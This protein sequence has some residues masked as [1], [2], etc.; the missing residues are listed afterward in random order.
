MSKIRIYFFRTYVA[1]LH[2]NEHPNRMQAVTKDGHEQYRVR[3]PK[4]K[5]GEHSVRETKTDPTYGKFF[6]LDLNIY[7]LS[8]H[9]K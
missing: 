6:L 7:T 1:A 5:K 4:F 3:F 9:S 2:H 8:S